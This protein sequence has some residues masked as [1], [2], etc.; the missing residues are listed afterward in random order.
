MNIILKINY[1]R[2]N[3]HTHPNIHTH[4]HI[5]THKQKDTHTLSDFPTAVCLVQ[6]HKCTSRT[7]KSRTE[8]CTHIFNRS[9]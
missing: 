6:R 2:F 1:K 7:L 8:A 5:Y 9:A 4:T 3:K